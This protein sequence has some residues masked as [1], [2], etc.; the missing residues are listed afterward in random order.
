MKKELVMTLLL[1]LVLMSA[2]TITSDKSAL[3]GSWKCIANDVPEEYKNSTINITEKDG[4]ST[5]TPLV[6][7]AVTRPTRR[8]PHVTTIVSPNPGQP[9]RCRGIPITSSG[10]LCV[11]TKLDL[12]IAILPSLRP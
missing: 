4:T 10:A 6:H 3:I 8:S 5:M 11:E 1:A 12:D 9:G 2:K 7:N